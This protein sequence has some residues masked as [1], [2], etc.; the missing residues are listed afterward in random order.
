MFNLQRYLANGGTPRQLLSDLILQNPMMNSL[1]RMA[2]SGNAQDV[3]VFARNLYKEQGRDFDK[4]F[5]EFKKNFNG[6]L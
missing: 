3:E 1:I 2:K 4:E 5:A 6:L